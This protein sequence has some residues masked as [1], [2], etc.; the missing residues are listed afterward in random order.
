MFLDHGPVDG[1]Q[2]GASLI[3][4]GTGSETAKELS[5]AMDTAGDHGGGGG[6]RVGDAFA[7]NSGA[8]GNADAGLEA[9]KNGA[10]RIPTPTPTKPNAF[11]MTQSTLFKVVL[12]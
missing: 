1:A 12:H 10:H 4:G 8:L 11:P 3:E 7:V 2:L 5:H 6:L 9:P